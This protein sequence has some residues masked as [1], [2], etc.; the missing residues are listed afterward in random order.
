MPL[1]FIND[2]TCS[3]QL[4]LWKFIIV[5]VCKF[6]FICSSLLYLDK[7]L[8]GKLGHADSIVHF[9]T[10]VLGLTKT[11]SIK[12]EMSDYL[13]FHK[14]AFLIKPV[15]QLFVSSK[16]ML[17]LV[18]TIQIMLASKIGSEHSSSLLS[19]RVP[20]VSRV[21]PH[22][23]K[24][25]IS[26]CWSILQSRTGY[27]RLLHVH[28]FKC[29]SFFVLVRHCNFHSYSGYHFTP[30]IWFVSTGIL[31]TSIMG[32]VTLVPANLLSLFCEHFFIG[33][34]VMFIISLVFTARR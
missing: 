25:W 13:Y 23:A 16:Y 34:D 4:H 1:S 21:L 26:I 10:S 3:F 29:F 18:V 28:R 22:K 7:Q 11:C 2:C 20:K 12:V 33:L 6:L 14:A 31:D 15:Y 24:E 5:Y 30:F 19:G 32:F 9:G 17:D 27:T 8:D